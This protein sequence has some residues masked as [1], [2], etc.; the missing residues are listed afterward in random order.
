MRDI[1]K[2]RYLDLAYE[3]EYVA[4]SEDTFNIN[5][6]IIFLAFPK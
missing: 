4:S 1:M 2:N 6:K 3:K 5:S